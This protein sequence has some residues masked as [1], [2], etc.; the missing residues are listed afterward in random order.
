MIEQDENALSVLGDL[1]AMGTRLSIDSFGTG[2][3]SLSSL[4]RLPVDALKLDRAL[5]A[6]L[7]DDSE[8]SPVVGS[9]ISLAG[10]LGLLTIA[11]GVE[12]PEQAAQLRS[13]GCRQAQGYLFAR[14][15]A[16]EKVGELLG[17]DLRQRGHD[18]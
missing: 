8:D 16:P 1:K 3:S 2:R 13:L 12:T 18:I 9:V 4:K 15:Q 5:L 11:V 14:P 17:P 6:W 7:G 10:S